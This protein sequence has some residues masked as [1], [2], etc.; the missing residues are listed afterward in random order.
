MSAASSRWRRVRKALISIVIVSMA[1]VVV[2][3]IARIPTPVQETPREE[4]VVVN[5]EVWAVD[6]VPQM[7]DMLELPAATEP[8]LAVSVPVEQ[9]GRIEEVLVEEGQPVREG[10]PI[11]RLDATLLEAEHEQARAQAEFDERNYRRS[12][13]L[14]ER[15]VVN[16]NEVEGLEAR[17]IVSRANLLLARTNLDRATV[18]SPVTGVLNDLFRERG[19]YV[20][21]GDAVAQ[22]VVVDRLKVV[23]KIPERDIRFLRLGMPIEVNV[24]ALDGARV[25]G[26]V[27]YISELSDEA[28]RT[29]R[30]DV[31]VD[32]H[33]RR[34]RAGMI[35]RVRISRQVLRDVIMIPLEAVIPLEDGRMVYV[36]SEGRAQQREVA[37]GMMR[38][39]QVQILEGLK[40]GDLL[41]VKGHRQVG[42]GQGVRIIQQT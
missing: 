32:N 2:F 4:P 29:T 28:T 18:Y 34:L 27:T 33:S 5:V 41:I 11:L 31:T 12:L 6:P 26:R 8:S 13:D 37:L 17:A 21:A 22:I 36:V 20:S 14:L 42:P 9:K 30:V 15:G 1:G 40:A 24:D 3:L 16:R 19:E 25:Q 7:S 39:S 38:G 10:D 35:V 23:V